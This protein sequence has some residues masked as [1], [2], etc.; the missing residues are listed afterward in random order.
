MIHLGEEGEEF[1]E[2]GIEV[3]RLLKASAG[4]DEIIKE[5]QENQK[6]LRDLHDSEVAML[7]ER[8]TKMAGPLKTASAQLEE[9]REEAR[10]T[11]A[12]RARFAA[13]KY[14]MSEEIMPVTCPLHAR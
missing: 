14:A 4:A 1:E 7:N 3:R 5:L 6:T 13:D 11:E 10:R 9:A 12:A 8:V 2:E